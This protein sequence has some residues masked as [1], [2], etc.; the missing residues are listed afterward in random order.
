MAHD[1][2]EFVITDIDN[3]EFRKVPQDQT[4][5]QSILSFFGKSVEEQEF[6]DQGTIKPKKQDHKKLSE[7]PATAI[8]GND[9]TSS[10]LYVIGLCTSYA[11][12][13]APVCL[14]VVAVVLY[15]FKSVYEEVG[16]AL[17]LNGASYALLLNTTSKQIASL[18]A[19]L[20][21]ISYVA[22]AVVSASTAMYYILLLPYFQD[23]DPVRTV[24]WGTII[25]LLAFALLNLIG[26][27]ESA[28]AAMIIF[29]L[30][31]ACLFMLVFYCLMY[32]IWE[33]KFAMLVNNWHH[34]HNA[35]IQSSIF[36]G[37]G[38][39]MLGITGFES[40]A[41]FI[42]QQKKGVFPKTLRNMWLAVTFFNP[43]ISF[44]S[45]CVMPLSIITDKTTN[46]SLLSQ[47]G[48]RA[49]GRWLEVLLSVDAATVLCGGVLTAYVGIIGLI[50]QMSSD[51]CFPQF[52]LR[53]NSARGTNHWIILFF[54]VVCSCMVA[55]VK[56]ME[57]LAGVYTISFLSVMFL[58]AFGDL[59]LKYKRS[60]LRRTSRAKRTIIVLAMIGVVVALMANILSGPDHVKYFVLYYGLTA[61][62]V[63]C[64]LW[65]IKIL[66][67]VIFLFLSKRKY[68]PGRL[69]YIVNWLI[70]RAKEIKSQSMIY[71]TKNDSLAMLNKAILYVRQN[72]LT[73]W[74]R[75]VH[76]VNINNSDQEEIKKHVQ[77]VKN[78]VSSLDP[79]YDDVR[80]DCIIVYSNH[81]FGP[82]VIDY[83]ST[84]YNI[85][86]NLM[87]ISCPSERFSHKISDLGGVRIIV[88]DIK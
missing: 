61:F 26:I 64:M 24:F 76:V 56:E 21:I 62:L 77:E 63:M 79:A 33:D 36:Y 20:T 10:C 37:F 80:I 4:F 38:A 68:L 34:P 9:I 53:T 48:R 22:T 43:L 59:V 30:H 51:R 66:S 39:G 2:Q 75:V 6:T 86:K 47:M 7:L 14:L 50:R 55:V 65:R 67:V 81:D 11:G 25:I 73:D 58:F 78:M 41:N 83:I 31:L 1:G 32:A 74:L 19:C 57:S 18:A 87:F 13:W 42:E 17:A 70:D 15:L 27:T 71:Y 16:S 45:L 8:C 49:A 5:V 29:L 69:K 84:R 88:S 23:L 3:E 82:K 44:L 46:Q 35:S 28:A 60:R 52:F 12:V 72:E 85:P 54:F 40:S